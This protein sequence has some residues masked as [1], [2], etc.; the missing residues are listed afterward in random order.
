MNYQRQHYVFNFFWAR[1]I[2]LT[3]TQGTLILKKLQ[4][5]EIRDR[6]HRSPIPYLKFIIFYQI[7]G[8]KGHF[9]YHLYNVNT[10][11]L[12]V[13]TSC[14]LGLRLTLCLYCNRFRF[15]LL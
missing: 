13:H 11:E 12:T 5:F 10:I 7:Y 14:Y 4:K 3:L 9:P 1:L 15:N 8:Y 6:T 2:S